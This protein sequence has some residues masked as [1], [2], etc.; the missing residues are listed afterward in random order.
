M[1]LGVKRRLKGFLTVH[2]LRYQTTFKPN[3]PDLHQSITF[4]NDGEPHMFGR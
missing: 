1:A 3:S 4:D 2:A